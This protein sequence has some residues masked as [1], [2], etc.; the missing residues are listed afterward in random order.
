MSN[1][2]FGYFTEKNSELPY[3][4]NFWV[5]KEKIGLQSPKTELG[6]HN[7]YFLISDVIYPSIGNFV[8]RRIKY[9]FTGQKGE[10]KPSEPKVEFGLKNR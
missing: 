2:K 5:K 1:I 10:I 6:L 3:I 4:S 8:W 9:T 7:Q